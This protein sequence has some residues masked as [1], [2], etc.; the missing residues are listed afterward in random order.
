MISS[1]FF[2]EFWILVFYL[3]IS[4]VWYLIILYQELIY[5]IMSLDFCMIYS[6]FL[7]SVFSSWLFHGSDHWLKNGA[8][9]LKIVEGV[10]VCS[11]Y[12][13]SIGTMV[14][15]SGLLFAVLIIRVSKRTA[16]FCFLCICLFCEHTQ[17]ATSRVYACAVFELND[18]LWQF[19]VRVELQR[20]GP[21]C[22]CVWHWVSWLH[23]TPRLDEKSK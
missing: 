16:S 17:L 7:F 20:R 12:C 6:D 1:L 22:I 5:I 8:C 11:V 15:G 9:I 21:F 4:L 2:N 3:I 14:L 18:K 13:Y 10:I 19:G 23:E